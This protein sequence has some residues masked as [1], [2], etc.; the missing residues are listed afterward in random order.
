MLGS[1]IRKLAWT[2][3]LEGSH[4]RESALTQ[5]EQQNVHI[6]IHINQ[7]PGFQYKCRTLIPK[8]ECWNQRFA[9]TSSP[10][11]PE[12]KA[13]KLRKNERFQTKNVFF[14]LRDV[15]EISFRKL[16]KTSGWIDSS[17]GHLP[18]KEQLHPLGSALHHIF[19]R[20]SGA[21]G[22]YISPIMFS[23]RKIPVVHPCT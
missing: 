20:K 17:L 18:E 3:S 5:S 21:L 11:F 4:W 14:L 7:S 9:F 8:T 19:C 22:L 1:T 10:N 6:V 15:V 2:L 12:Q 16:Q 23:Q 13:R